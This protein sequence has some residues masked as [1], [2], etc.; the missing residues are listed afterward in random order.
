MVT[1]F[2]K[3]RAPNNTA[4]KKAQILIRNKNL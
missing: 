4:F 2:K 3:G 1:A